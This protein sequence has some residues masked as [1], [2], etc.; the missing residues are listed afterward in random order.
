MRGAVIAGALLLGLA[1]PASAAA[2]GCPSTTYKVT[3][4]SVTDFSEQTPDGV[5]LEG[6]SLPL[7][8]HFFEAASKVSI[9]VR[10]NALTLTKGTIFRTGCYA[11]ARGKPLRP[12]LQLLR[13]PST[14]ARGARR[15]PA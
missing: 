8:G 5:P 7:R 2:T 3:A 11:E 14:S 4:G 1:L 13:A 12:A 9:A 6:S 10:G 15:R